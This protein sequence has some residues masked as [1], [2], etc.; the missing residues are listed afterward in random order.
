MLTI[1][2]DIVADSVTIAVVAAASAVDFPTYGRSHIHPSIR[3]HARWKFHKH[4]QIHADLAQKIFSCNKA[5][6]S[7]ENKTS[8]LCY[9][10]RFAGLEV[11]SL[12]RAACIGSQ[13]TRF[14]PAQKCEHITFQMLH[15]W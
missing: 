7:D 4:A 3:I 8:S 1:D 6:E 12:R 13:H 10:F 11:F 2:I 15:N 5:E 9:R 14:E